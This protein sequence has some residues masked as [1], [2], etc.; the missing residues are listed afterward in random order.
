[1]GDVTLLEVHELKGSLDEDLARERVGCR[2]QYRQ[3]MGLHVYS[4]S[5]MI[6]S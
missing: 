3:C 1:M 5:A 4:S 6:T 2:G